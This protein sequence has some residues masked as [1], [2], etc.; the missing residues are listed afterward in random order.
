MCSPPKLPLGAYV[1]CYLVADGDVID[2]G[3]D[4]SVNFEGMP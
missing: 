4:V 3:H 1:F 2:F